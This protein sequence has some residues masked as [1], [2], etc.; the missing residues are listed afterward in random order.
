[1]LLLFECSEQN[2]SP[3]NE[4]QTW[5]RKLSVHSSSYIGEGKVYVYICNI[6]IM[7][8]SPSPIFRSSY[9]TS[10]QQSTKLHAFRT[11]SRHRMLTSMD[12]FSRAT[13]TT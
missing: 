10:Q 1:M 4:I 12:A 6:Y 7:Y 9:T 8:T 3:H 5:V 11:S 2:V 13:H